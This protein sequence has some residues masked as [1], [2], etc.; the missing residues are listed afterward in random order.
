MTLKKT[1]LCCVVALF[2]FACSKG[3]DIDKSKYPAS[4]DD[5]AI[6]SVKSAGDGNKALLRLAPAPGS[7]QRAALKM[8]MSGTGLPSGFSMTM[9]LTSKVLTIKDDGSFD[10]EMS[11]DDA[12][13]GGMPGGEDLGDILAG[14]TIKQ[15]MSARGDIIEGTIDTPGMAGLDDMLDKSFQGVQFSLP[16]DKVGKG[17]SWTV[18]SLEN[19]QNIRDYQTITYTVEA[20]DGNVVTLAIDLDQRARDQKIEAGFQT[21]DLDYLHTTG[22]GK[23]TLDLTKPVP[24]SMHLNGNIKMK[25]SVGS[26]SQEATM[27]MNISLDPIG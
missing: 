26:D 4:P 22:K 9:D 21:A 27:S 17:A 14:F 7:V 11:I 20:I 13:M 16:E 10:M 24:V 19:E 6:V 3:P 15:T 12:S 1:L 5:P 8:S 23:M 18:R 2:A 25:V